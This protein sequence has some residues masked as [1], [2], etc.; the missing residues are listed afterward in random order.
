MTT[1]A[2]QLEPSVAEQLSEAVSLLGKLVESSESGI[3]AVA[4]ETQARKEEMLLAE[5][6]QEVQRRRD[7]R[8]VGFVLAAILVIGVASGFVGYDRFTRNEVTCTEKQARAEV[9]DERALIVLRAAADALNATPAERD[10]LDAEVQAKLDK[11][12]PPC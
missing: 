6:R 11:L 12:P 7:Q 9:A 10:A 1:D 3:A 2:E 4:A 5:Q 8:M